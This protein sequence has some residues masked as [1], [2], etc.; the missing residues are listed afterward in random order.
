MSQNWY[1]RVLGEEFG[2]VSFDTVGELAQKGLLSPNDEL[3]DGEKGPWVAAESIVGLFPE[4]EEIRDLA[5]LDIEIGGSSERPAADLPAESSLLDG[6]FEQ[7][8]ESE[9]LS[10]DRPDAPK[11]HS[12]DNAQSDKP[13]IDA[14]WYFQVA[15]REVGP[16]TL[17]QL[18]LLAESGKLAVDDLV[19]QSRDGDWVPVEQVPQLSAAVIFRPTSRRQPPPSSGTGPAPSEEDDF[20]LSEPFLEAP[21]PQSE[22]PPGPPQPQKPREAAASRIDETQPAPPHAEAGKKDAAFSQPAD[23]AARGEMVDKGWY[24]RWEG[25]AFG[26]FRYG[27]LKTMARSLRISPD[28]EVKRGKKGQWVPASTCKGLFDPAAIAAFSADK[29]AAAASTGTHADPSAEKDEPTSGRKEKRGWFRSAAQKDAAA[30]AA[31]AEKLSKARA[32]STQAA[33]VAKTH[34]AARSSRSPEFDLSG[35]AD[36][37]GVLIAAAGKAKWL[38]IAAA[39]VVGVMW[40]SPGLSGFFRSDMDYYETLNSI[41]TEHQQLRESGASET[42]WSQFTT[43]VTSELEPL[44]E[45]LKAAAAE[46]EPGVSKPL[47]YAA[48]RVPKMLESARKRPSPSEKSFAKFLQEAANLLDESAS[49]ETTST[50]SQ[51]SGAQ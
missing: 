5:E 44:V 36:L 20:E 13:A 1:Y 50:N 27:E 33:A 2:P 46:K 41:Y 34:K 25:D 7:S 45:D 4:P 43:R 10:G 32:K 31:A 18:V 40:A 14:G 26:P 48:L 47:Y 8:P 15:G 17:S 51:N 29:A 49:D 39:V 24:Y 42:E 23:A 11:R 12:P 37:F 16:V 3:R 21:L 9:P 6:L 30:V 38:A 35:I 28:T 19:R 22:K